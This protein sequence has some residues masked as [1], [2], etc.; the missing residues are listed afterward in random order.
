MSPYQFSV[1]SRVGGSVLISPN[2]SPH[3]SRPSSPR[4]PFGPREDRESFTSVKEDGCGIAQS[5]ILTHTSSLNQSATNSSAIGDDD[6]LLNNGGTMFQPRNFC[7]PCQGFGG[8]RR[9]ELGGFRLS[10]SCGDLTLLTRD[11]ST[12]LDTATEKLLE[13]P[14]LDAV[15]EEK[16]EVP[17]AHPASLSPIERLPMEIFGESSFSLY[18]GAPLADFPSITR[19][20]HSSTSG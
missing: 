11:Y 6:E 12:G 7:C 8:W 4:Q 15:V 5:F 20:H 13:M 14:T 19:P 18:F 3:T 2:H 9:V 17:E 1:E 10:K 16:K